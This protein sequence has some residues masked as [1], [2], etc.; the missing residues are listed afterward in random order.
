MKCI[1]QSL[2]G[3]LPY[4]MRIIY[5]SLFH[6]SRPHIPITYLQSQYYN[7]SLWVRY[8]ICF[9]PFAKYTLQIKLFHLL[10]FK[11]SWISYLYPSMF[12]K[13]SAGMLRYT[14]TFGKKGHPKLNI[15]YNSNPKIR[16][17]ILIRMATQYDV[18]L[19][20]FY[21]SG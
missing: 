11:R 20:S 9:T 2:A 18:Q 12:S 7:S 1:E 10:K 8:C 4:L 21:T 6:I 3:I 16:C 15:L 13:Y 14:H 5:I 19:V 17:F